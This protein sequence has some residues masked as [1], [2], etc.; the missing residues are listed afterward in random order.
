MKEENYSY[1]GFGF[2]FFFIVIIVITGSAIL[3]NSRMNKINKSNSNEFQVVLNDK[4]KKDKDE[5][6]IY[7]SMLENVSESLNVT[8]KKAII[9]LDSAD[10][11]K[12]NEELSKIYDRALESIK[13][14]NDTEYVCENCSD[15]YSAILIE[16]AV[17]SY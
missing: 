10:A 5:D 1:L 2:F 4:M 9:N 8:Q 11:K 7:Y 16:Y 3:Y 6:Y 13:R 12:V 15:L 14:S 17:Y